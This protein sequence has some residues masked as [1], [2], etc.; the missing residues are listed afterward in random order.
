MTAASAWKATQASQRI[1]TE[2]PSARSSL[3]LRSSALGSS[4]APARAENAFIVSGAPVRT[5]LRA[6]D[7]SADIPGQSL[8][9]ARF[10]GS[11]PLPTPSAT[12]GEKMSAAADARVD[13]YQVA[14]T[15][16]AISLRRPTGSAMCAPATLQPGLNNPTA[17]R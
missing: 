9:I 3:V 10:L 4:A 2:M 15:S 13:L 6:W 14:S 7:R 16:I 12:T 1:A 8:Y 17:G 11:L 5:P